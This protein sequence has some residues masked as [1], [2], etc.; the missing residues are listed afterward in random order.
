MTPPRKQ[1]ELRT[2][3]GPA[4]L[5]R[6]EEPCSLQGSP[7]TEG[8]AVLLEPEGDQGGF[9]WRGKGRERHPTKQERCGPDASVLCRPQKESPDRV[10]SGEGRRS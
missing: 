8:G 6:R 9:D 5:G 1:Q 2:E 7:M 3:R 10:V 4:F